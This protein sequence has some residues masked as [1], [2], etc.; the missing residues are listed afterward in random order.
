MVLNRKLVR[1][2]GESKALNIEKENRARGEECTQKRWGKK[3]QRLLL[4]KART[5]HPSRTPVK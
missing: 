5:T 3:L 4:Y 1:E 2:M